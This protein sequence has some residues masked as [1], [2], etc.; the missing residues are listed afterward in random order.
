M[1][2]RLLAGLLLC[3]LAA[4]QAQVPDGR[5][6]VGTNYQPVDRSEAQVRNDI[7]RMKQAGFNIVRMGD[8]SWDYFEPSDGRFEFAAFDAVMDQM[9]A[10][11]IRV[12]L[13][14]PGQPAPIWLH[15]A[16]P[17]VDIVTQQGVR[18]DAAE[19]YMDNIAD[20]DYR[21]LLGRM[22][23]TLTA[24][25]AKHPALLAVGYNNEI[26]NGFMSYS[27]ADQSRFVEWLQKKYG[28]IQSLN[29]AW[30]TLTQKP[31]ARIDPGLMTFSCS[32]WRTIAARAWLPVYT[33]D[34]SPSSYLP[35]LQ[36]MRRKSVPSATAK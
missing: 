21:R 22:A 14:I 19:R 24:R 4:A 5:L 34:S 35:R 30:A 10:A 28:S 12:I 7:E 1:K 18:Q 20:P 3:Q 9:H 27:Q 8:L 32:C 13:E 17:G 31:S 6:F 26:G 11:G 29:R 25:Y 23:Q 36:L 33:D 15:H 16:Y 2:I